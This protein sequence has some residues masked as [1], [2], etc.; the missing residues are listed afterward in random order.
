MTVYSALE[1]LS[2]IIFIVKSNAS[3][4]NMNFPIKSFI[5]FT[6]TIFFASAVYETDKKAKISNINVLKQLILDTNY[7]NKAKAGKITQEFY[8]PAFALTGWIFFEFT[9][10]FYFNATGSI[11]TYS[12]LLANL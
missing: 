5:S 4:H 12:L 7:P 9:G 3:I 10:N 11:I 6:G 8:T 2:G 1:M